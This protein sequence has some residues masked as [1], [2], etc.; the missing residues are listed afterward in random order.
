MNALVNRIL[1]F[2]STFH[3]P[4]RV[5]LTDLL[6]IAPLMV[7][8]AY[9]TLYWQSVNARYGVIYHTNH[10]YVLGLIGSACFSMVLLSY[11]FSVRADERNPIRSPWRTLWTTLVVV[12]AVTGV[13]I[14]FKAL[15]IHRELT[16]YE[17]FMS[18]FTVGL[19]AAPIGYRKL[20]F[21]FAP[22]RAA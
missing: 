4:V 2:F 21:R 6:L 14:A 13:M 10:P 11:G 17:G 18:F 16:V 12:A 22:P 9:Y 19:A 15:V 8:G 20:G 5:A 3:H 7:G 1:D